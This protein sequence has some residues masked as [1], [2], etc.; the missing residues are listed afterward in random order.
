LLRIDVFSNLGSD[1]KIGGTNS[2]KLQELQR[3][4]EAS[5]SGPIQRRAKRAAH[6]KRAKKDCTKC[7]TRAKLENEHSR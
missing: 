4:I 1:I 3:K 5:T 6:V 7:T 2:K